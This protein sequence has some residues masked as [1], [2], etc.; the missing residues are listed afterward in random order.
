MRTVLARQDR[1]P[2]TSTTNGSWRAGANVQ[3]LELPDTADVKKSRSQE[4]PTKGDVSACRRLRSVNNVASVRA[5]LLLASCR[6]ASPAKNSYRRSLLKNV[7]SP[8]PVRGR[9]WHAQ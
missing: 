8:C 9:Q 4:A 7:R 6:L 2:T 1:E 3:V 5:F